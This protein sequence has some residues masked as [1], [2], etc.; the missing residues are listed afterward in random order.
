MAESH[1]LLM[2]YKYLPP[3]LFLFMFC[4]YAYFRL[5]LPLRTEVFLEPLKL[6]KMKIKNKG[7]GVICAPRAQRG[8]VPKKC[9]SV[10]KITFNFNRLFFKTKIIKEALNQKR[11]QCHKDNKT[12]CW[13]QL[14]VTKIGNNSISL[15]IV[16][17]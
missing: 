2:E 4:F 5:G 10:Y 1:V 14:T 7:G 17:K 13:I 6:E 16:T 15:S 11:I 8:R 3:L 12:I 9:V